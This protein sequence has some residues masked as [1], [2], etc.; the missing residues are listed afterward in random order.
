[1][2]ILSDLL[3]A[4]I[5][6]CP[7]IGITIFDGIGITQ[8]ISTSLGIPRNRRSGDIQFNV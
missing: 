1:L 4:P 6:N 5:K 2:S 3:A 7:P 8:A